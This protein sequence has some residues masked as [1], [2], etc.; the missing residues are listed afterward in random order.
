MLQELKGAF[1]VTSQQSAANKFL[2]EKQKIDL[3]K[4]MT[5]VVKQKK[6]IQDKSEQIDSL[7][8]HATDMKQSMEVAST[9][10]QSLSNEVQMQQI[11]IQNLQTKLKESKKVGKQGKELKELKKYTSSIEKENLQ[12]RH[13][14]SSLSTQLKDKSSAD[15]ERIKDCQ[16]RKQTYKQEVKKLRLALQEANRMVKEKDIYIDN[17]NQDHGNLLN[18]LKQE[19]QEITIERDRRF[20]EMEKM[21]KDADENRTKLEQMRSEKY[22]LERKLKELGESLDTITFLSYYYSL[23]HFTN[24]SSDKEAKLVNAEDMIVH[25]KKRLHHQTNKMKSAFHSVLEDCKDTD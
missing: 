16:R 7:N 8:R 22:E 24:A 6:E 14:A 25:L 2:A 1:E 9:K 20:G 12:L 3:Q 11:T 18:Q 23:R 21:M 10:Y 17:M 4:A 19:R 5:L 15:L 13:D